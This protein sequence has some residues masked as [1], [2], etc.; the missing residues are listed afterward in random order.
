METMVDRAQRF[1]AHRR[2]ALVGA[3]REEQAFSRIVLGELLRRGYDVV[4]VTPA[5]EEIAGHRCFGRVQDI[6][7]PVEAALVMTAPAKTAEVVEDCVRA[8]VRDVWLHRGAGPGAGSPAALEICR[9]NGIVPVTDLCPFMA[10]PNAGVAHR[11]HH[12][13]RRLALPLA[14]GR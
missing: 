7:P 13:F 4:P 6:Q 5:A 2:I 11:V 14:R 1:L 10:L 9:A 12:F 8:G 3:S